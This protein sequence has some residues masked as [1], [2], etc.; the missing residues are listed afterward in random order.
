MPKKVIAYLLACALLLS[1]STAVF[2]ANTSEYD[3]VGEVTMTEE[4]TTN[5]TDTEDE[6]AEDKVTVK[7]ENPEN[8]NVTF[9]NDETEI[10]EEN[11]VITDPLQREYEVGDTCRF[12]IIP[13]EG[14]S[15]DE[16]KLSW[17]SDESFLS[18]IFSSGNGDNES[19]SIVATND[20]DNTW[21]FTVSEDRPINICV[22]FC[23]DNSLNQ[24]EDTQIA[25][26]P[27]VDEISTTDN[28]ELSTNDDSNA[29]SYIENG[30]DEDTA[31]SD[32]TDE[33]SM[34][35]ITE[36]RIFN[37]DGVMLLRS[38]RASSYNP[39]VETR[40][41]SL[42]GYIYVNVVM[43]DGGLSIYKVDCS[44]PYNYYAGP[45][46]ITYTTQLVSGNDLGA[47]L[48]DSLYYTKSDGV[49][50][51]HPEYQASSRQHVFPFSM[52]FNRNLPG[53][54]MELVGVSGN[55]NGLSSMTG[56]GANWVSFETDTN[57]NGMTNYTEDKA[58]RHATY[59]V[60]YVP[61]KY[62][63]TLNSNGGTYN[64]MAW[65]VSFPLTYATGD[66][67]RIGCPQRTGYLF[68]GWFDGSGAQIYDAN[69]D[70]LPCTYWSNYGASA[71]YQ[72]TGDL[73]VYAYWTPIT[74]Y[75]SYDG[76]GSTGGSTA[77]STLTYD[78]AK[79]LNDNGYVKTGYSFTGWNTRAD[80]KGTTYSNNA[81]VNNLTA[82]HG[83]T[84]P[85]Y[86]QWKANTYTLTYNGN[87]GTTPGAKKASYDSKWGS[88]A[89]SSRTGYI[90]S[91]WYDSPSGG[92]QITSNTVCA[93]NKTV[94]AHWKPIT[95]NISYNGNG[96]TG[97]S[98][99][100]STHTYDTAKSLNGNGFEK[101][102]YS[103]TGWNTSSNGS[104]TSY[105]DKASVKNLS[106]TNGA[107]VNLYAQWSADTYT[108]TF[109][110]NGGT[111][112]GSQ[113]ASYDSK[114]GNLADSSRIGYIFSGWYD[115]P[116]GGTQITSDTVCAGNK[117]VYA[118]WKPIT[119]TVFYD[120]NG[121]TDG[122]T[123]ASSHA[124][125]TASE[126]TGNGF[127]RAG[128][129]FAGWNTKADGS[130]TAYNDKDSIINLTDVDGQTITL[131]AQW[132]LKPITV[133]APRSLILN[134]DGNG[135]FVI[136][137]D[138]E[139]GTVTVNADP[140]INLTQKGKDQVITGTVSLDQNTLTPDRHEIKGSINTESLSAGSWNGVF[141]LNITFRL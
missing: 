59:T 101:T 31:K 117:T 116:S 118:H 74:Y 127:A 98:T 70:A 124:F 72:Y 86:A 22:T 108:I 51:V 55:E 36:E 61:N 60:Q 27:V 49:E 64:S 40:Y 28:E 119:Y 39:Y 125:D 83:A 14:Y 19:S 136:K 141:N 95:Y 1:N 54:H 131:Y 92:T 10:A 67:D 121:N 4:T 80:G 26:T 25:D 79:S 134:Q 89:D 123:G 90:F 113:T 58:F 35:N 48:K 109:D 45:Q 56:Y 122:A 30:I 88:L 140:T 85:L 7:I 126:L 137:A 115:S 133:S 24:D 53:Y 9:L 20:E 23:Q 29:E 107:T 93:G 13:D 32:I 97:G 6:S 66:Y 62:T 94:Y 57:D 111:T 12:S 106:S 21:S 112:P 139:T 84:I 81:S 87:G 128:Y 44:V 104:G 103:F 100:A 37:N 2:A 65:N 3:A 41:M 42:S 18:E 73:T 34:Y 138:N 16:V 105:S 46:Q 78:T 63:L 15:I 76:N 8:G 5:D 38:T 77:T 130:G 43:P 47:T 71:Y 11:A 52:Q 132:R 69:G 17:E 50:L 96:N 99:A 82:T 102:G 91:G 75:V 110:G 129:T 68:N 33:V 120:G 135:S 114:W